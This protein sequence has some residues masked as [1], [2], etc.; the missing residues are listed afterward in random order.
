V[1]KINTRI[2][3]ADKY[4]GNPGSGSD[5][6]PQFNSLA[7]VAHKYIIKAS[8]F[9]L[10]RCIGVARIFSLGETLFFHQKVYDLF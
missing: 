6:K 3:A 8:E 7:V 9:R 10:Y 4:P 1:C 2:F 5:V